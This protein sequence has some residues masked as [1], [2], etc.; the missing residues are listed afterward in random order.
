MDIVLQATR[1][2]TGSRSIRT[3]LRKEGKLPGVIYGFNIESTP[4]ALDYKQ[5]TQAIQKYGRT[6]LF[7]IEIEGK[8]LNVIVNE[9]QR[10]A[11]KGTVK[12]VDFQSINMSE[13]LEVDVPIMPIG[14]ASGVKE[15]GVL[16]QPIREVKIKVKPANIPE[17]LEVDVSNLEIGESISVGDIRDKSRFNILNEDEDTLITITPPVVVNDETAGQGNEEDADIK[18]TEAPESEN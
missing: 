9:M 11:L 16:T 7:N 6:G 13:E 3:N 8:K 2:T 18:A 12:H 15:G 14:E 17:S 1:R 10:C 5:T 4:V